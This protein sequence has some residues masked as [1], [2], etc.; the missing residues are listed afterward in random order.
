MSLPELADGDVYKATE[1]FKLYRGELEEQLYNQSEEE[2]I[3]LVKELI[4]DAWLYSQHDSIKE[5]DVQRFCEL[6]QS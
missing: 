4:T 3:D 5:K 6:I 2:R 1:S